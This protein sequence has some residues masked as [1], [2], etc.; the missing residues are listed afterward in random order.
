M[1]G[2]FIETMMVDI[3]DMDDRVI[4]G[5]PKGIGIYSRHK[6]L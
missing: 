2:V 1:K 4:I 6:Q 5:Q 3:V